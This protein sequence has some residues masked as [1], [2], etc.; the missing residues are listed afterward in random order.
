MAKKGFSVP[1]FEAGVQA[2]D[3][4]RMAGLVTGFWASQIVRAVA[5]YNLADHLAS[6][7]TTAPQ[8][9]SA[10]KIDLEATRR[11]LRTCA[12][13]GLM[14]SADGI[15]YSSTSLLNT[16]RAGAP[17]S[18]RY[19]A[20]S[21]AAPGHWQSWGKF[22][23]A[24]RT[25]QQQV[26]AAHGEETIFSYFARN[27]AE[28][29]TFTQ[30]M[31]DLSLAVASDAAAAIDTRD[32]RFALDIGGADG[33]L[34]RAMMRANPRLS[35]G[36]LDLPHIVPDAEEAARTD[37]LRDRFTAVPGDF[38]EKVPPADMYL[39]KFILHDWDDERSARVLSNCRASLEEGGRVV[40]VDLH[41]GEVGQ[42]G[43]GP[44]MD[45]N[46]LVMTGGLE[47]PVNDLDKLLAG[48]GLRRVK[49]SV[50]G[51]YGI[52]EAVAAA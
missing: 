18:M 46:M 52:T 48:A 30:S 22:P 4:D 44:L 27:A 31:N 1:S 49:R 41:V 40:I 50:V 28:A 42:P 23:D 14:T 3:Y 38:F 29:A 12:S 13:M 21:Q 34:V 25:G 35:G 11:L 47:R 17:N 32:V 36:V 5:M 15:H 24:V 37:G 7:V 33:N 20:L 10:E 16:L 2:R 8:I 51:A 9:A 19:F 39:L 43:L 26:P 45:M 6:G